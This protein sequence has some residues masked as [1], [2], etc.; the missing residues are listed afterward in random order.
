MVKGMIF[1]M[2]VRQDSEIA[3]TGTDMDKLSVKI[4]CS[5]HT[6]GWVILQ[7]RMLQGRQQRHWVGW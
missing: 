5:R 3:G 2:Y 4:V 1:A 6:I 7:E